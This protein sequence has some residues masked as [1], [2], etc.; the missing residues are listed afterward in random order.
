M[1]LISMIREYFR[2][3]STAVYTQ[4]GQSY[5]P[6]QA[7]LTRAPITFGPLEHNMNGM[8]SA[9]MGP[10]GGGIQIDPTGND[11]SKSYNGDVG[12]VIK[13][14]IAHSIL[15]NT[16]E[17]YDNLLTMAS[18]N[19]HY[20]AM[21]KGLTHSSRG[22][23][24]PNEVPA[25]AAESNPERYG[26]SQQDRDAYL[27]TLLDQLRSTDLVKASQYSRLIGK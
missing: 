26:I 7:R 24:M 18:R 20:W 6:A 19:S 5:G 27:H 17:D 11:V 22:G 15:S 8:Y 4:P 1:D 21:A 9:R 13:H 2:P 12:N 16:P 23:D 14:E 10:I 25:Y 3:G